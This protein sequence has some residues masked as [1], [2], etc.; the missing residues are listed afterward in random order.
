M[1][2]FVM[3]GVALLLV[4]CGEATVQKPSLVEHV[5]VPP[6]NSSHTQQEP[7]APRST[8]P[9]QSGMADERQAPARPS[10]VVKVEFIDVEER[11]KSAVVHVGDTLEVSV[12]ERQ[13]R[14]WK[15]VGEQPTDSAFIQGYLGPNTPGLKHIWK[16]A[17][18]PGKRTIK[19]VE[20]D[21]N[22]PGAPPRETR[23][24]VTVE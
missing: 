17:G 22:A 8:P 18:S 20:K 16:I 24:I 5:E 21:E 3:V 12:P 11:P 9:L 4:A 19:F 15:V 13:G 7:P 23:L 1:N 6:M 10:K 2:R 14:G